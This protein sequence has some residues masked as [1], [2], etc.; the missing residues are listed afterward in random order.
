M[1]ENAK[2]LLRL[3]LLNGA[4]ISPADCQQQG[5]L[6]LTSLAVGVFWG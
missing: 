4:F 5:M 6:K 3:R 2:Q 1:V